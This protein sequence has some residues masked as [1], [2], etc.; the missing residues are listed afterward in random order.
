MAGTG[1]GCGKT[2]VALSL[3]AYFS[4]KG[5]TVAAFK[6]GPD[7]IDAAWLSWAAGRPARNL[8]TY[9]V[10][11]AVVRKS[12]FE[13]SRLADISIIEG[14]RGLYDGFDSI[15]THST[16][17]LAK[18]LG[19]PVLLV[20]DAAKVTRTTAAIALGMQKLDPEVSIA[21]V[22]FN[23]VAGSRH[24]K[25]LA[26]S[27]MEICDLPTLGTIPNMRESDFLPGRH[28]GLVTPAEHSAK[29]RLKGILLETAEKFIDT[30]EIRALAQNASTFS[31]G[32]A[33]SVFKSV[34]NRVRIACFTDSAFTFY[35][36]DNLEALRCEGAEIIPVSSMAD[37]ELPE[38]DGLYIGGGFPETHLFQLSQNRDLMASVRRAAEGGLPI[39]AECGGLIYLCQS[40]LDDKGEHPMAGVFPLKLKMEKRP[41]GHGY[42]QVSVDG[43]TPFYRRGTVIKG[44][45][46][47]YT[48]AVS[49]MD[50]VDTC[51][52]VIRG[53]GCFAN[54]DGLV[55][56]SVFA[57][58][59]H[60][61]SLGVPEWAK[62]F[63]ECA[64]AY[65]KKGG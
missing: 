56:K 50:E 54:R 59:I 3:T 23:R 37:G 31:D 33:P 40:L 36:P 45:E 9:M 62:R 65:R 13:N 6:K 46:F 38:C 12:F 32:E 16:A 19:V 4:H 53:R 57:S 49:G 8:D 39:Y 34:A 60:V 64:E 2:L 15:G 10:D 41:Q 42:C 48:R 61:H 22:I 24:R 11:R 28:L 47:H 26:E 27:L 14:N 5:F 35:Y 7:Y 20:I 21:G 29:D 63:V 1:G 25:I 58:Y 30:E 43:W 55:Y 51:M 44:H 17:E 18:L 52:S